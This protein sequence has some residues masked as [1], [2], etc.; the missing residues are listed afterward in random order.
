VTADPAQTPPSTAT[1]EGGIAALE[2]AVTVAALAVV[3]NRLTAASGALRASTG[4]LGWGRAVR[5]VTR[6]LTSL[7]PGVSARLQR[8]VMRGAELGASHAL[9]PLPAGWNPDEDPTLAGV[10]ATVDNT[11]RLAARS[12]AREIAALPAGDTAAADQILGRVDSRARI[13]AV[14]VTHRSVAAGFE[15]ASSAAGKSRMWVSERNSCLGC[16]AYSGQIAPPG[17]I[18]KGRLTYGKRVLPWTVHGI[19]GPPAHPSCRCHQQLANA[20]MADG[21]SREAARSVAKGW[22]EYDSLPERLRAA[23]AL[24]ASLPALPASVIETAR[25]DV[26]RGGFTTPTVPQTRRRG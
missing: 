14:T 12:A 21:L 15:Q 2:T 19:T 9:A 17:G 3:V 5:D 6:A 10:F 25:R 24:I 16:L 20:D 1:I 4:D 11:V 7:Q 8:A 23:D 13:A 22:S 18:F 26:E